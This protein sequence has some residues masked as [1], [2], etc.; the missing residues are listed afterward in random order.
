MQGRFL[1]T[2]TESFCAQY[3]RLI[4]K[5]FF[6]V[7]N[8]NSYKAIKVNETYAALLGKHRCASWMPGVK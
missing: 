3:A 4:L 8:S 5:H 1:F 2:L 6:T 7:Q